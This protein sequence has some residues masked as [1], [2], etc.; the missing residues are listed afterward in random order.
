MHKYNLNLFKYISVP[1]WSG[2]NVA[3]CRLVELNPA[4]GTDE[5]PENWKQLHKDVVRAAY[6]VKKLK[7]Y[8][9]WAVAL[10]TAS[11]VESVLQNTDNVEAVS[12]HIKVRFLEKMIVQKVTY[13][14]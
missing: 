14:P 13:N 10:C 11:I 4:I 6:D 5:D 7:G 9:S 1:V 12:T 2:V 8:T 3:G